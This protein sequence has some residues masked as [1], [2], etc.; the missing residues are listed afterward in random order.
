[1]RRKNVELGQYD[2]SR[3]VHGGGVGEFVTASV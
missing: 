3:E 2:F 1:M